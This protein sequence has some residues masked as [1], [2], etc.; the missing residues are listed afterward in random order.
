VKV[1]VDTNVL[2]EARRPDGHPAVRAAL[3]AVADEDLFLSAITVGEIAHGVARLPAGKRRDELAA[4][5][6]LTERHFADRVQP[7]DAAVA[8]RWGEVTAAVARD[9]RVLHAADGLIAATALHHGL[10][11]LTGNSDDFDATGVVVV[12]PLN[13]IQDPDSGR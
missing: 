7:V 6:A 10:K 11:V 13:T 12:N 9:G 8:R 1:L 4:W 5:F 2:S 3:A